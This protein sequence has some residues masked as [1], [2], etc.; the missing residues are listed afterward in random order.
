MPNVNA[1]VRLDPVRRAA[2]N[3]GFARGIIRGLPN[4]IQA[5]GVNS[6]LGRV[7]LTVTEAGLSAEVIGDQGQTIHRIPEITDSK[8]TADCLFNAGIDEITFPKHIQQSQVTRVL[9]ALCRKGTT[10]VENVIGRDN[11]VQIN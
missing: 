10:D 1:Q 11:F 5:I 9:D 7:K 2:K 6:H 8:G 4:V 3:G